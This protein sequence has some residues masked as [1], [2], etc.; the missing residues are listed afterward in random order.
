MKLSI[1]LLYYNQ[2]Q[3]MEKLFKSI[4]YANIDCEIIIIDDFS[5]QLFPFEKVKK[6]IQNIPIKIIRNNHNTKNQS[7]CRNIGIQNAVG[8]YLTYIDGDDYYNSYELK[9]LYN[10]LQNRDIYLT[11]VIS[12]EK[13]SNNYY[14]VRNVGIKMEY[15][16]ICIAQHV[17]K[18][19]YIIE[20]N[21]WWNEDKY[22][23]DAEDL[24]YGMLVMTKTTD[25]YILDNWFYFHPYIKN[26][27]SDR[28]GKKLLNYI[29]YLLDMY[30]D[31]KK[32]N[33]I[34]YFHVFEKIVFSTINYW[35][36]K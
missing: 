5:T 29:I 12:Q 20:N 4:K 18:R 8:D 7:V 14:Q 34:K 23:W 36:E 32:L 31:I 22:Y 9:Q 15:P 33:N 30:E 17:D 26:S 13:K 3:Y 35:S 25:I 11:T 24:Y 19:S 21:L 27:N 6:I 2:E 10:K 16:S 1:I 28:V